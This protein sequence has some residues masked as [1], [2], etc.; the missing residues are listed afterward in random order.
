MDVGASGQ[1]GDAGVYAESSL[2]KALENKSLSL[3][4]PA[5]VE[6]I[7]SKISY[8]IVA[9]DAFPLTENIMKPFPHRNLNK[10]QRIFNYRLSQARHV[11]ENAFGILANRFRAFLT[12]IKLNP[13][14]VVD[15][16][17]AACCLHNFMVENNKHAYTS[18]IHVED[19]DQLQLIS[20]TWRN[21]LQLSGLAPTTGRNPRQSAKKQGE[22]LTNYFVSDHGASA[23]ARVHDKF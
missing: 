2:K 8:H 14:K 5:N 23:M 22:E 6:G 12:T 19:T 1:A 9:D 17:L 4:T 13:D 21:D 7:S 20:G 15:L 16:V 3:P 18:V 10:S 11:V